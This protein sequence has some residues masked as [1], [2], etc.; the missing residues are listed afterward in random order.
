MLSLQDAMMN[1]QPSTPRGNGRR[2]KIDILADR[3]EDVTSGE[4]NAQVLYN[5]ARELRDMGIS[6]E[7]IA[8]GF[9][10][11]AAHYD[12]EGAKITG[13]DVRSWMLQP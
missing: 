12:I 5:Q 13:Y 6:F 8:N 7:R 10:G 2:R 9:G 3:L 11:L 1:Q 4:I